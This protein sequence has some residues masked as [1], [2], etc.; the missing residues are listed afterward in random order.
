MPVHSAPSVLTI[1]RALFARA[2]IETALIIMVSISQLSPCGKETTGER[3]I[4]KKKKI[5]K[6]ENRKFKGY[7]V[8]L[9]IRFIWILGAPK[10]AERVY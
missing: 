3:D 9:N 2:H 6:P 8:Y 10:S 7:K 1:I 5:K 4:G